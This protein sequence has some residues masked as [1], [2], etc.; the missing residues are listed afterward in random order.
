MAL[1]EI[2]N[3]V[4]GLVDGGCSVVR[5]YYR[6][7]WWSKIHGFSLTISSWI[8]RVVW[9]SP[10]QFVHS[11]IVC[12][13]TQQYYVIRVEYTFGE[14]NRRVSPT[15]PRSLAIATQKIKANNTLS[16]FESRLQPTLNVRR[17]AE[18]SLGDSSLDQNGFVLYI[19][20]SERISSDPTM[21]FCVPYCFFL[22][23]NK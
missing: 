15:I 1:C 22:C 5:V 3:S 9:T 17:S 11:E 8:L 14:K 7:P 16:A 4:L 12:V 20:T 21:V 23:V 2:L 19:C 13:I 18:N 10:S 6:C